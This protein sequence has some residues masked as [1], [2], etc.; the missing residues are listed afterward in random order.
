MTTKYP[1]NSTQSKN[2]ESEQPQLS[3]NPFLWFRQ[4]IEKY[5]GKQKLTETR[6]AIVLNDLVDAASPSNDFFIMILFSSSIATFGLI[7]NLSVVTIGAQLIDPLM[8]PILGLSIASLSGLNRMF[9]R[10]FIAFIK[11]AGVAVGLSALISFFAYRLPYS[12]QASIPH[13]VMVRTVTTP[14]DLG[15]AI[16]G[17]AAAAYALAHP[18]L[19][20]ALPGVAIATALMPPLCTIG[21]GLAFQSTLIITGAVL[22]FFTNFV[23]ITFSA[24]VMFAL[25]GFIPNKVKKSKNL[26]RSVVVS[27]IMVLVIAIP[28]A[29]LSWNTV[30]SARL[31]RRASSVIMDNLPNSVQP[32]LVDLAINSIGNKRDLTI[33]LRMVRELTPSEALLLRDVLADQLGN[34]VTLQIITLPM[35]VID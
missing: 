2:S 34:P 18:R 30:S 33:T 7:A 16:V 25:L 4:I 15:I 35:Q 17:G 20:A 6:K 1:A 21:F 8:S 10:S 9:K 11:G 23:A 27:A 12:I 5:F 28:L 19:D 32:Q 3:Q 31:L 13:E 26:S 22:Q 24:I 14:L 29:I